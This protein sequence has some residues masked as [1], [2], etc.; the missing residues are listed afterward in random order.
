R[1]GRESL[2]NL[3]I[4]ARACLRGRGSVSFVSFAPVSEA[5]RSECSKPIRARMCAKHRSRQL[6][7]RSARIPGT[8]GCVGIQDPPT[9]SGRRCTNRARHGSS[10]LRG[11]TSYLRVGAV[12]QDFLM[13]VLGGK[14]AFR[15]VL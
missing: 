15:S 14:G 7:N 10:S 6:C 1:S 12:G 3:L 8:V 11:P 2:L 4:N 5:K 13:S 9:R